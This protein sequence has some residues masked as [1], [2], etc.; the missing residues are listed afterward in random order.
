MQK[1][2]PISPCPS[3][4]MPSQSE[5]ESKT[6]HNRN[7]TQFTPQISI[8]TPSP[9]TLSFSQSAAPSFS[10]YTH[11]TRN[12]LPLALLP[13]LQHP[14]T[15]NDPIPHSSHPHSKTH[16]TPHFLQPPIQLPLSDLLYPPSNTHS[17]ITSHL[18]P[19]R[20]PSISPSPTLSHKPITPFF[21][22][23]PIHL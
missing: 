2:L 1:S 3:H 7:A 21:S 14:S 18:L 10:H 23:S 16:K 19:I 22:H 12:S 13:I 20:L 11:S 15:A 17:T 4:S 8:S 5:I 9:P 6:A